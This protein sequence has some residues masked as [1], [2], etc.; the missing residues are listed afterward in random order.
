MRPVDMLPRCVK[1][2]KIMHPT[3]GSARAHIKLLNRRGVG[4]GDDRVYECLA[5]QALHVGHS[6]ANLA[7][8]INNVKKVGRAKSSAA[9]R[10]GTKK[11]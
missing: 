3:K 11:R 7:R 10:I 5:C 6:R 4:S 2:H 1:T 9:S 8:R